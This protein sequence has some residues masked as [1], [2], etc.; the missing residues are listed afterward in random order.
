MNFSVLFYA[1]TWQIEKRKC[2]EAHKLIFAIAYDSQEFSFL[3]YEEK[4][5]LDLSKLS[6]FVMPCS[7]ESTHE[8]NFISIGQA[9]I[10]VKI[11]SCEMFFIFLMR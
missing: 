8:L 9:F 7:K 4:I 1:S 10:L 3:E 11:I 2:G 5:L 6:K